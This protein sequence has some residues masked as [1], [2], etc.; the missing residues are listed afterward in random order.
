LISSLWSVS[1]KKDTARHCGFAIGSLPPTLVGGALY[2]QPASIA[3]PFWSFFCIASR[4]EAMQKKGQQYRH[5]S[6]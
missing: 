3:L 5:L 2:V 1:R 6:G 4:R